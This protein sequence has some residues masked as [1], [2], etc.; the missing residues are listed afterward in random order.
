MAHLIYRR[1]KENDLRNK[2]SKPYAIGAMS[3]RLQRNL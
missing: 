2:S 3:E 1:S